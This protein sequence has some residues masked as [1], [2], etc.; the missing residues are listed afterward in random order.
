MTVSV[1]DDVPGVGPK[2]KRLLMRHF[3]SLKRLRAASE[4]EIAA[5]E[6]ISEMVAHAIWQAL[7][8]SQDF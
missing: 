6:G 8:E 1:L 5:T 2:R 7:H 4:E 3:G